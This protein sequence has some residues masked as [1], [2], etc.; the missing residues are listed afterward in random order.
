M[1]NALENEVTEGLV[2]TINQNVEQKRKNNIGLKMEI[3]KFVN[4]RNLTLPAIYTGTIRPD[5]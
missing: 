4:Y 3:G 1:E 2:C 5:L